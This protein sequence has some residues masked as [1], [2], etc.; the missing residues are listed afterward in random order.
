MY[1]TY[2]ILGKYNKQENLVDKNP[3]GKVSAERVD[4]YSIE[5]RTHSV[6]KTIELYILLMSIYVLLMEYRCTYDKKIMHLDSCH[7]T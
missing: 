3:I 2:M 4:T 1:K 6:R 7:Q 5:V